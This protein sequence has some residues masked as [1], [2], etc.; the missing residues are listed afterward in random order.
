MY[1]HY[2]ERTDAFPDTIVADI[3]GRGMTTGSY[4][5]DIMFREILEDILHRF[6]IDQNKIYS[7]GQSNGGFSTWVLAQKTPDIFAAINPSTGVFN[8]NEIRCV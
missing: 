4:V 2:F 8:P 7:M 1:S 5:G 3:H 6:P